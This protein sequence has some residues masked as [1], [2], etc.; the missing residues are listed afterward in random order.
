MR[1]ELFREAAGLPRGAGRA[2][3]TDGPPPQ[4]WLRRPRGRS[5]SPRRPGHRA[6]RTRRSLCRQHALVSPP[7]PQGGRWQQREGRRRPRP[8]IPRSLLACATLQQHL[9]LRRHQKR[10]VYTHHHQDGCEARR[11]SPHHLLRGATRQPAQMQQTG[12][13]ATSSGSRRRPLQQQQPPLPWMQTLLSCSAA[14]R[15]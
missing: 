14:V 3:G 10:A 1:G 5:Q 9:P 8:R 6:G 4:G 12:S 13:S 11:Q 7:A 15:R 2:G